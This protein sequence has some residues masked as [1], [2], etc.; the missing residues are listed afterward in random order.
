MAPA[1]A[2]FYGLFD[3]LKHRHLDGLA[4]LQGP[5][6]AKPLHLEPQ[7]TL[8]YGALAGVASELIVYPLEVVRRRIQIQSMTMATARGA[9]RHPTTIAAGAVA[10]VA[11]GGG[12]IAASSGLK[13]I[14]LTCKDIWKAEGAGGFYSGMAPNLAQV[15]PSSALSYY[16]FDKLKQVLHAE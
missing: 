15:L 11:L 7:W 16:T 13:R 8:L 4:A 12:P 2:V 5:G 14:A 6:L 10:A 3:L 1:G 9:M